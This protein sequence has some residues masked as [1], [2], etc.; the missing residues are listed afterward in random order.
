MRALQ[1]KVM[2]VIG[3]ELQ[4]LEPLARAA[5]LSA[6]AGGALGALFF[7]GLWWTVRRAIASPRPG[8]FLLAS[9]VLRMSVLIAGFYAVAEGQWQRLVACLLGFLAA[10]ML[11]RIVVRAAPDWKRPRHAA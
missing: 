2:T 10:R 11:V 7:G 6:L 8:V 5:G 4:S 1:I 9:L 3:P